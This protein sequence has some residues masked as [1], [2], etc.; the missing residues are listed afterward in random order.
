[1]SGAIQSTS[2]AVCCGSRNV[3]DGNLSG[4]GGACGLEHPDEVVGKG[5]VTESCRNGEINGDM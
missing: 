2:L 5:R 1:M 4:N 3:T